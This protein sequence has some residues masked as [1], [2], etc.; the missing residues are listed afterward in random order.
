MDA[1]GALISSIYLL[2][3]PAILLVAAA[4]KSVQLI[5]GSVLIWEDPGSWQRPEAALRRAPAGGERD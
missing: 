2:Q 3:L 4:V 1:L 5:A